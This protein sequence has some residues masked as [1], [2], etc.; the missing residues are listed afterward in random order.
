MSMK[1]TKT[2]KKGLEDKDD[3]DNIVQLNE[4]KAGDDDEK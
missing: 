3:D 1:K 2:G 4:K